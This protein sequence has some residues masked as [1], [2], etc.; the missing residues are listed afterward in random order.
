MKVPCH[1]AN[2]ESIRAF[3]SQ[4]I[5][6]IVATGQVSAGDRVD[7][8]MIPLL[9]TPLEF[10]LQACPQPGVWPRVMVP[11]RQRESFLLSRHPDRVRIAGTIRVHHQDGVDDVHLEG[12][13]EELEAGGRP[14]AGQR[15]ASG[16]S[17]NLSFDEAFGEAVKMLTEEGDPQPDEF[18]HV[19]VEE[20]GG[21][22]GGIAGFRELYVRLVTVAPALDGRIEE[23]A[24]E[25]PGSIVEVG[26]E[27]PGRIV[28]VGPER[29][30][31]V[32]G[33]A[34]VIVEVGPDRPEQSYRQ[35]EVVSEVAPVRVARPDAEVIVEVAP[36]RPEEAR[37]QGP[38]AE[39]APE[40]PET[41]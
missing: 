40:R 11:Y 4:G 37:R 22:F 7:I 30:R 27:R 23:I 8:E 21:Y 2:R 12:V 10:R 15:T 25:R 38:I 31:G 36:Q 19:R 26:P 20:V 6:S 32:S 13:P 39:V 33:Q 34:E 29:P 41:T 28:E 18:L 5:L 1:L 35:A 16:Y 3:Y 14:G 17:S 9:T 24:P